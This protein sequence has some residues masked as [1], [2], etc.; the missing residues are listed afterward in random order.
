MKLN[1]KYHI[2]TSSLSSHV[3]RHTF[4][5]RCREKGIDLFVLQKIVGH[6]AGSD[7]TN[8]VYTSVSN[9]FINQEITKI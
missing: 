2:T 3:L 7:I 9:E 1:D 4:I 6:V 8:N 5:T